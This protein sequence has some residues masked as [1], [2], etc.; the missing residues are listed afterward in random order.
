MQE[1]KEAARRLHEKQL[2]LLQTAHAAEVKR[3]KVK[4]KKKMATVLKEL[5]QLR[6]EAAKKENKRRNHTKRAKEAKKQQRRKI[7]KAAV[8][9]ATEAAARA[10][11]AAVSKKQK[12]VDRATDSLKDL[13]TQLKESRSD[14]AS[15]EA[16]TDE[17]QQ[18]VEALKEKTESSSQSAR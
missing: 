5:Q 6:S 2:M 1:E 13:Q 12:L 14:Y 7:E 10:A 9:K 17:L 3:L 4:H 8:A 18:S 16:C 15:L 11:Q